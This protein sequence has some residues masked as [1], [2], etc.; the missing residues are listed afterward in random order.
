MTHTD[1]H[2][3]VIGAGPY[4]LAA[5]A[6]LRGAGIETLVFGRTMHFWKNHMPQGMLLRSPWSAS[7][8]GDPYR[9]LTLDRYYFEIGL[10]RAEPVSLERFLEYGA[11]FQRR[12]VPNLDQR[13]IIQIEKA[14]HGFRLFLEDGSVVRASRVVIATGIGSFA[15]RPS[16]FDTIPLELASHSSD[17]CDFKK[18]VRRQV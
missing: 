13:Q 5:A 9:Q 16:V 15:Y 3:A 14:E 18:F 4:G 10:R 11:W 8:I 12:A 2:V 6:H 17:H 7:H 1:A